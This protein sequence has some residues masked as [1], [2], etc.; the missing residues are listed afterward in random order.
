MRLLRRQLEREERAAGGA[1]HEAERPYQRA[2]KRPPL[3]GNWKLVIDAFLD[4]Y[5]IRHLHR[6]SIY[7]FFV[8]ALSEAQPAG[9]HIRAATARR[10]LPGARDVRLEDVDVRQLA[11]PSYVVFPNTVL[12]LHPDYTSVLTMTPEAPDPTRFSHMMLIPEA[13]RSEAEEVHWAKSFTL[14]D[15]GVF[16]REDLTV[17]EAMQRGIGAGA[18]ETLLFGELEQAALWFHESLARAIART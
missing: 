9:D 1:V 16:L 7:R 8:D 10:T 11:T 12:I 2:A 17:V 6:D 13:P 14:I 3:R 5:H 18:N 15:E 4:G